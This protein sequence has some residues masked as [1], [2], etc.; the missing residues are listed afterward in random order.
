MRITPVY[1]SAQMITCSILL[2][3][4]SE[5]FLCS[6]IYALNTVEER[7][8]LW[9]DIK[10]H[11]DAPMFKNKKWM[12]MGDYNEILEGEEHSGFE[13]SPRISMGMRDFQDIT[14]HCKLTDMSYHGPRYT[15]CNKRAEGLICKKLDRV[16]V[17]EV[18]LNNSGVTYCV[19]EPGGC[20]DHLRCRVQFEKEVDKKRRPFK[21]TN[22]IANMK[23]F[24]PLVKEHWEGYETLYNSTSAMFMLTKRLKTLKQPLRILSKIKL[25]DLSRR[26][27]EAYQMLCLKQL[28]T[29]ERNTSE[30][31]SEESTAY[32]K[33]QRLSDL[34]EEVLKQ[35]SKVHWLDVGDGNNHYFHN[36][37]KIREVRNAIHEVQREDGSIAQ[38]EDE[39]K[40]EA[41]SFFADFMRKQPEEFEGASVEELTELLDFR[42]SAPD[43]DKL[44]REVTNEEIRKVLFKMPSNKAPGPDGYTTEF[45]KESWEITGGDITVAIQ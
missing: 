9:E 19:F 29:L 43:S 15:W 35:R 21:F 28:E 8:E 18:W 40:K 26:T 12:L 36:S 22:A 10:H 33:W 45:F 25:G 5:E 39:I 32:E 37:A 31:V 6:F 13:D 4:Q 44:E 34:E 23:E 16:L 41:E 3:K 1:K 14:R 17:N 24:K 27:K 38:T 11:H 7:K 20:S 2:P 30:A 42:C